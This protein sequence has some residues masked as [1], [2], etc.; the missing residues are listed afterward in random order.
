MNSHYFKWWF[1]DNLLYIAN[2]YTLNKT[3]ENAM[4]NILWSSRDN[5]VSKLTKK[6]PRRFLKFDQ[7]PLTI[8][9]N[10]DLLHTIVCNTKLATLV[11]IDYGSKLLTSF[12]CGLHYNGINLCNKLWKRANNVT[13]YKIIQMSFIKMLKSSTVKAYKYK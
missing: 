9:W 7:I 2:N 11:D 8:V 12:D 10:T 6:P 4:H 3:L 1:I 5:E 13:R